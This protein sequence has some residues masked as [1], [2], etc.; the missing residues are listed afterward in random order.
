MP[1]VAGLTPN[2]PRVRITT[3]RALDPDTVRTDAD[4]ALRLHLAIAPGDETAT[5]RSWTLT[6]SGVRTLAY[7]GTGRPPAEIVVRNWGI[8]IALIGL[9]LSVRNP[10]N[11]GD[12]VHTFNV[13]LMADPSNYITNSIFDPANPWSIGF[14]NAREWGFLLLFIGFAIKLPMVPLHTWLPDAHVEAP[15]PISVILA[16]L[17]LKIGGYGFMRIAFPIFPEAAVVDGGRGGGSRDP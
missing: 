5:A 7:R 17:L 10:A 11:G 8:L 13:L 3:V 15:T 2:R 12:V 4:G 9:Y 1:T 6:V 14:L 16:A